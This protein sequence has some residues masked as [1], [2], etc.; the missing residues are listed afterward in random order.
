MCHKALKNTLT[1]HVMVER[2][3]SVA[4]LAYC[5]RVLR[6]N[7]VVAKCYLR[8]ISHDLAINY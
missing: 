6:A 1:R 5:V 3:F 4:C 7:E 8:V 2:I